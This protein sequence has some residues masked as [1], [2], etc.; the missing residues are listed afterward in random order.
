MADIDLMKKALVNAHKAGDTGAATKIAKAIKA[1]QASPEEGGRDGKGFFEKVDA[2]VR[3]AADMLTFGF[4]DEISAG[5]GTGFG[6]LGDYDKALAEQ[7]GID[8]F[9]EKNNAGARFTGQIA[10]G[11][12]GGI[13]AARNGA[14]LLTREALKKGGKQAIA[15]AAGEGAAYGGVYG[16]GSGEGLEDRVSNA[17]AGALTGAVTGAAVQ[18]IGNSI[19]TRKAARAASRAALATDQLQSAKNALYEQSRAAGVTIKKDA[20]N[21]LV[22]NMRLAAGN[23]N[24]KLR[25]N[26][27]GIVEDVLNMADQPMTL[28]SLDELRQVVGQSMKRAQPQDQRTLMRMKDMIDKFS[29]GLTAIDMTGDM[30]GVEVLKQAR[31][32]NART[33]KTKTIE[34]IMD[35][36]QV[37]GDGKYTQ[38]GYAQAISNEMKT[39]Y[40]RILDGREKGFSKEEVALIRQMASGGP[41]GKVMRLFAKFAPRG[42]VSFGVGQGI[43]SLIPG[44][45][46][47]IPGAGHFAAQNVD[48]GLIRASEAL[49][50]SAATGQMPVGAMGQ[51]G[52]SAVRPVIAPASM[53]MES[54]RNQLMRPR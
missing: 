43:G 2:G 41:S 28:E 15:R 38:S 32:L 50:T 24:D 27:A 10:G 21:R 25:P 29:D 13:G 33:A 26:T 30:A 35:I 20:T 39:L 23:L 44:G 48:N 42:V 17:G 7:R 16:F 3:G 51:I 49:R 45:N 54:R 14:T 47:L 9:D 52:S 22:G 6:L 12:T 31:A 40:K 5:M 8:R 1:A 46:I 18:K 36:A 37:K 11:L 53:G 19:A 4:A 34:K